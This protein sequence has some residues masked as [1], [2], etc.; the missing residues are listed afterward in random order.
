[1][2]CSELQCVAVC[3][4]VL[5]CVAVCCSVL[6]C[7]AVCCSVLHLLRGRETCC[8]QPSDFFLQFLRVCD[9]SH[10]YV[11]HDSTHCHTL[12]HSATHC[13]T[14]QHTA[15]HCTMLHH[16]A[17]HRNTLQH[18]ATHCNTLLHT[19]THY[20]T[21]LHTATKLLPSL[22]PACVWHDSFTHVTWLFHTCGM[23]HSYV[24]QNSFT[25]VTWLTTCYKA[26]SHMWRE[27]TRCNTLQHAVNYCNTL[28]HT[29]T[30]CTI[31]QPYTNT[32]RSLTL[33]L[34]RS[35]ALRDLTTK[36]A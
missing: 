28:L 24:W 21:L 32:L 12:Q 31:L 15:I 1:V 27:S 26:Y 34:S 33:S 16:T 29:A 14:L 8:Q 22:V 20:H 2:R 30:H 19:A 6:Q 13:N 3:C 23:T 35:L 10:S 36:S 7:V 9:M 4:S 11:W 25:R 5:P 17:T 18:I